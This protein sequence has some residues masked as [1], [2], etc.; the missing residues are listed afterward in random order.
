[1][2]KA[3]DE[4]MITIPITSAHAGATRNA[5][6][7]PLRMAVITCRDTAT[8]VAEVTCHLALDASGLVAGHV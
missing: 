6:P 7:W 3:R 2:A 8:H 1:M 4:R 5:M